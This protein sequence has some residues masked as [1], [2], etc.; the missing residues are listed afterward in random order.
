MRHPRPWLSAF[1]QRAYREN[2][3]GLS[4]MV[5]YNLMLAVFPFALLVL[6]IFGQVLKIGG[7]ESSVLSDLQR[8]FPNVEQGT[9]TDVLNRIEENSTTIG[10]AAFFGSLWIGAS[11]WG[12]MDTA[13][14][15][16]YHVECRGWVEQKRFSFAMLAVVLLFIAASIFL[17]AMESALVSSTDRLPFGLSDIK[18][19]DTTLLL[20]AAILITFLIC[21]VIFWAVPKGHMPWRAVW[22]GAVFVTVSAG[23]AN[24]LFPVYL[25]NVS[26]LSR[27]GSTLGFILIALLWF[28]VLSLA[29]MAGAVI[30]SLRHELHDT[31]EMPYTGSSSP[32]RPGDC[33]CEDPAPS[34]PAETS[35]GGS[36]EP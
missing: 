5:A 27:F 29:L 17:P 25:S 8:L 18:V 22:P 7:V 4:A 12:A 16:I 32:R 33:G 36:G 9:L 31:G 35:S 15:R 14:C 2:V 1:W 23:V 34:A 30:N 21:C 3:T 6:F 13:F 24:W 28:Y 11:F 19:I 10:I 26:S 20:G